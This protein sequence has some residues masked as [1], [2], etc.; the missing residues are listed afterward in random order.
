[1]GGRQPIITSRKR[2]LG[3][4]NVFTRVCH[5]VYGGFH[6][7]GGAVLGRVV[8]SLTGG[9]MKGASMKWG[10]SMKGSAMKGVPST[11]GCYV[12]Y[13]NA[14]LLRLWFS[15]H[16]TNMKRIEQVDPVQPR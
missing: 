10:V 2:G 3:Q 7:L 14:F 13:W 12:S 8:L 5:S 1:M 6:P 16:C 9:V 15:N 11:S 4:G